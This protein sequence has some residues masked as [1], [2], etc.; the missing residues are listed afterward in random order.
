MKG[1]SAVIAA[2][3]IIAITILIGGIFLS[4]ATGIV[5]NE[6]TTVT[7]KTLECKPGTDV[8][9]EDIFIDFGSNRSRVIVR[10]SGT[11]D[12]ELVSAVMLNKKGETISNLTTFP[13][14]I[15]RGE[16][17]NL[18]FSINSTTGNITICGNFSKVIVSTRCTYDESIESPKCSG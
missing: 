8:S 14:A 1:L 16:I 5:K 15:N 18:E 3:I 7:N 13:L 11:E 4:W 6:Q 9:V 12:Q 17:K 2:V 10:N